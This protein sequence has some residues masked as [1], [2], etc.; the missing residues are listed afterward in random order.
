MFHVFADGLQQPRWFPLKSKKPESKKD[1]IVTGSIQLE[2]SLFDPVAPSAAPQDV[3]QKFLTTIGLSQTDIG[4]DDDQD[5]SP[6]GDEDEE[7]VGGESPPGE[8]ESGVEGAVKTKKKK[9]IPGLARLKKKA[10]EHGYEFTSISSIAGVLFIEIQ[11]ATDLPPE[12][13]GTL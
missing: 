1:S 8:Q 9:R 11:K 7:L 3:I 10:K 12:R 5:E 6:E 2:F 13:N 4:E